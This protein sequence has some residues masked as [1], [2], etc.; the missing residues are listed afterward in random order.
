M[1][2]EGRCPRRNPSEAGNDRVRCAAIRLAERYK[3]KERE[4]FAVDGVPRTPEGARDLWQRDMYHF[5]K[6]AAAGDL[7]VKHAVRRYP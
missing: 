2:A 5:H 3:L 4:D 7:D 1:R 6:W